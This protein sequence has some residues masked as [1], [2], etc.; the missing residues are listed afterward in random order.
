[1]TPEM[2]GNTIHLLEGLKEDAEMALDGRW[3]CTSEE[4][5]KTGF[6]AQIELINELLTDLK[7]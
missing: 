6:S 3:D 1:M 7:K 5:I 2:L 4:G